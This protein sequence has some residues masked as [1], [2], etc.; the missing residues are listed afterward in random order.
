MAMTMPA[1]AVAG[2]DVAHHLVVHAADLADA[3]E[4]GQR[5]GEQ[6][7]GEDDARRRRCRH[8]ARLPA[9]SPV[10]RI[11]KP[12]VVRDDQEPDQ[13]AAT[14]APATHAEMQPRAFEQHREARPNPR[15]AARSDS[16]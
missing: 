15:S 16:R 12:S 3:G 13:P 7:R 10:T 4:P 1:I 2:R 5:A 6:R 11:A 8:S 9:F 14:T